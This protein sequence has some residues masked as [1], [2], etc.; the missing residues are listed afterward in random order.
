MGDGVRTFLPPL[1]HERLL[2]PSYVPATNLYGIFT[3]RLQ[4]LLALFAL[5]AICICCTQSCTP[6]PYSQS[7]LLRA[8]F[9]AADVPVNQCERLPPALLSDIMERLSS[10]ISGQQLT[11]G[12]LPAVSK[13]WQDTPRFSTALHV[14]LV[15]EEST[16]QFSAWLPKHGQHLLGMTFTESS[17]PYLTNFQLPLPSHLSTLQLCK[18]AARDPDESYTK[19]DG[20]YYQ[21]RTYPGLSSFLQCL[22]PLQQ[23]NHLQLSASFFTDDLAGATDSLCVLTSLKTLS[24][25]GDISSFGSSLLTSIATSLVSL[26]SLSFTVPSEYRAPRPLFDCLGGFSNLQELRLGGLLHPDDLGYC[27]ELPVVA[28]GVMVSAPEE[29]SQL[30]HWLGATG[31]KK[32]LRELL[33]QARYMH[34]RNR[35]QPLKEVVQQLAGMEQL[36]AF[37]LDGAVADW[38]WIKQ[39]TQLTWLDLH[40]P[41]G[42]V[43]MLELPTGVQRF[44]LGAG[45]CEISWVDPGAG[46][47][48]GS[49][50]VCDGSSR[51]SGRSSSSAD[52]GGGSNGAVFSTA[53]E[54]GSSTASSS[55][56][57]IIRSDR[58]APLTSLTMRVNQLLD[59]GSLGAMG[60]CCTALRELV[61]EP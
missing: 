7:Y 22:T 21:S 26:T 61:L 36:R 10:S 42:S 1:L 29:Y 14:N 34:M 44:C 25:C 3:C 58:F 35:A 46:G 49:S 33:L 40:F 9:L 17:V 45:N 43:S 39:L 30:S 53:G 27:S 11:C 57:S 18:L 12:T 2:K 16:H 32:G 23:L 28:V 38:D 5:P 47:S 50:H 51:Y 52:G 13:A 55:S 37:R 24:I 15:N 54:G 4:V 31:I 59:E 20:G 41:P 19:P 56:Y 8:G 48:N 60:S 6:P